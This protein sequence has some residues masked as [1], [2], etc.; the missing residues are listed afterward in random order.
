ME[1]VHRDYDGN[2]ADRDAADIVKHELELNTE[3]DGT[4]LRNP[5]GRKKVWGSLWSHW[6]MAIRNKQLRN[7]LIRAQG[8]LRA[9]D[10]GKRRRL[11]L[12]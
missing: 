6:N 2:R 11:G 8:R 10:A 3:E 4:R 1:K 7:E 9:I 5:P 12:E